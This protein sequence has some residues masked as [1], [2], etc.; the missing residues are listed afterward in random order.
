MTD[1]GLAGSVALVTGAAGGIGQAIADR[2]AEAGV[3][4]YAS[5]TVP[6]DVEAGPS[7][8]II[9][10]LMDVT[11]RQAVRDTIG[12]I[13]DESGELDVLINNAGLIRA[14]G[15]FELTEADWDVTLDVNAKGLLFCTQA[16]AELM[17]A[18]A[19]PG[20]AGRSIVNIAST[21]GRDGRT[22]SPPYAASKAAVINITRS[23][24]RIL[25]PDGI[26][27]NAVC[28]GVVDTAFNAR[29]GE[30][31]APAEGM[32]PRV[33]GLEAGGTHTDGSAGGSRR[34]G[35]RGAVS[36]FVVRFLR[37]GSGSQCRRWPVDGLTCPWP[38]LISRY[39]DVMEGLSGKVA[40]VT[41]AA[42]GI[43]ART[44]ELLLQAKAEV[45]AGDISYDALVERFR[46]YRGIL[47]CRADVRR[48]A[49]CEA[50]AS[51]AIE[52]HGRVDILINN[53]GIT[54][55]APL[56]G[57]TNEI[58]D[59]VLQTNL[60]SAFYMARAVVPTMRAHGGGTIVNIAS[61][62]AIRGNLELTAYGASKGGMTGMTRVH[63]DGTGSRQH[64]RERIVSRN[65]GHT[66][67]RPVPGVRR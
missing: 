14:A 61:I 53:A 27:V 50:L 51:A 26:R 38:V 66:D 17:R 42:M 28:P 31:F 3:V 20:P 5:D 35:N 54:V 7:G 8:R 45:V 39:R 19:A 52:S 34:G 43:G 32:D 18:S 58:W 44:A 55:R 24:A 25:A 9:P 10:I 11:D 22:M 37:H 29:L 46:G 65:R 63:G 15:L 57:T 59:N 47:P 4:V 64:P 30:Q 41:G 21:A 67:E 1:W 49:D 60:A 13:A 48:N 16:A 33:L 6:E 23:T 56:S 40:I 2:L 36:R 12:H 62:N